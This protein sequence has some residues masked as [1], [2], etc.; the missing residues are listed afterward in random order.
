MPPLKTYDLFI[1]HA[2]T[3][4]AEYNRLVEML[5][6]APNFKWRN[7]SVTKQDPLDANNDARLTEALRRQIR[8]VN[9]VLILAGMY[10]N[11]RKWIRKEIAIAKSLRKP[12]VGIKPWGQQRTPVEVQDAAN[13]MVRW[14]TD[15]IVRAIRG[16]SI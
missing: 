10:V 1:S 6:A 16:Y 14:N 15:S 12:I 3:Y 7:Y 11:H 8:P 4:N 5:N 13:V 2:W 9:C